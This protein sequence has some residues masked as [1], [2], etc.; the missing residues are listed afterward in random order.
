MVE[1][2]EEQGL[3]VVLESY[4]TGVILCSLE[5]A[6]ANE[7]V[8]ILVSN[9]D[10]PAIKAC[11]EVLLKSPYSLYVMAFCARSGNDALM[12]Q[13]AE[14]VTGCEYWRLAR[15]SFFDD[16][17]AKVNACKESAEW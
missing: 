16:V 17:K 13:A 6:T 10:R 11:H 3:K 4:T 15:D 9:W 14:T 7:I 2:N 5:F 8:K 1:T 12:T